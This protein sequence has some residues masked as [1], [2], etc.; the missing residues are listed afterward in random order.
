[1]TSTGDAGPQPR[2]G[3]AAAF[4]HRLRLLFV[5]VP[6]HMAGYFLLERFNPSLLSSAGVLGIALI[7]LGYALAQ[8]IH[9]PQADDQTVLLVRRTRG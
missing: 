9:R 7:G 8:A 3:G 2:R 6:L 4:I 1:M 5:V